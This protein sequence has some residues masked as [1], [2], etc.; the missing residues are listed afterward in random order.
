MQLTYHPYI[1]VKINKDGANQHK[2]WKTYQTG[3]QT[4]YFDSAARA[5]QGHEEGNTIGANAKV[6]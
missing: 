3:S 2:Y 6:T 1:R 4:E 5:E